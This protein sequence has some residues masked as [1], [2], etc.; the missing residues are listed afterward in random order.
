MSENQEEMGIKR[1]FNIEYGYNDGTKPSI[2]YDVPEIIALSFFKA[3][4]FGN[5]DFY[6][7]YENG[8]L[9]KEWVRDKDG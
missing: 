3:I 6:N 8:E 5:F 4:E 7:V 9:V 2:V 1:H